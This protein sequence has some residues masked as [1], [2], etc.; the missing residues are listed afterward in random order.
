MVDYTGLENRRTET[1]RGFESLS[2]RRKS[3]QS[4]AFFVRGNLTP[5]GSCA[6]VGAQAAKPERT[7]LSPQEKME[8]FTGLHLAFS[9]GRDSCD[10]CDN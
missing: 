5:R 6:P 8:I 1:C 2:L 4:V 10:S 9:A 7:P 3:N